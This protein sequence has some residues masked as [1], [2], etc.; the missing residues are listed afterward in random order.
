MD[1]FLGLEKIRIEN[2]RRERTG[3]IPMSRKSM[4]LMVAVGAKWL[5]TRNKA[6]V[7]GLGWGRGDNRK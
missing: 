2:P 1:A 5:Q 7:V 3:N 6:N 4:G